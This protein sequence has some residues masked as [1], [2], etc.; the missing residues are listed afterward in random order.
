[1]NVGIHARQ[2]GLSSALISRLG[3][4]VPGRELRCLLRDRQVNTTALQTDVTYPTGRVLG[5]EEANHQ[6]RYTIEGPSAWD[7][8]APNDTDLELV[9]A[10]T[11][12]V[13]GSLGSRNSVSASTLMNLLAVA[14]RPVL[15]INLRSP[16][17]NVTLLNT[18]LQQTQ[19]LKLN[20]DELHELVELG[21]TAGQTTEEQLLQLRTRYSLSVVCL[22]L[23]AAGA[24]LLTPEGYVRQAGFPVTVVDT[25]GSGDA[26]LAALLAGYCAGDSWPDTLRSACVTG[27]YVATQPGATP[28]V[29][30]QLLT[31]FSQFLPENMLPV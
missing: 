20:D 17:Y 10:S 18:L 6:M 4:D 22:T 23:G 8:I 12:F 13:F 25:V 29:S 24:L 2:L 21:L 30:S 14:P 15:D 19:W 3:D 31:E 1:M 11:F 26:F 28:L 5:E 16:H 27:A 9:A 7:Y